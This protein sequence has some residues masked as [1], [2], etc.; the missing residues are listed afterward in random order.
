MV[1]W[2]VSMT[3]HLTISLAFFALQNGLLIA[4]EIIDIP[5]DT[6]TLRRIAAMRDSLTRVRL[7]SFEIIPVADQYKTVGITEQLLNRDEQKIY[8]LLPPGLFEWSWAGSDQ[9][10]DRVVYADGQKS[11][12][13]RSIS[14]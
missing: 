2:G 6:M 8:G 1:G 13:K 7:F 5:A 4:R 9:Q 3:F 12:E 14:Q 10:G 11:A